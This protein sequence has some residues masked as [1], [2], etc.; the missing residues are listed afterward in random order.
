L[1]VESVTVPDTVEEK[2]RIPLS[3]MLR[4]F[5]VLGTTSFGAGRQMYL[6]DTFVRRLRVVT[7]TEFAEGVTVSHLLPGASV[8]NLGIYIG[9]LQYGW[10]GGV[11]AGFGFLAPCLVVTILF[12]AFVRSG[13]Y[14]P[15]LDG[16]LSGAA[17][18][19]VA[20]LLAM[21]AKLGPAN[22]RQVRGGPFVALAAFAIAGPL[23]LG[24]LPALVASGLVSIWLNRPRGA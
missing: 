7:P 10:R 18:V 17:A 20:L 11:L 19:S 9:Y 5:L 1:T 4:E 21:I 24:V 13:E 12:A 16:V 8:P 14:P 15:I 22:F 23:Q 2:K 6:M 3:Q